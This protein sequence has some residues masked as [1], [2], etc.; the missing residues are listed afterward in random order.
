MVENNHPDS[1]F[2]ASSASMRAYRRSP[3]GRS[4]FII[5]QV[6]PEKTHDATR[7]RDTGRNLT[8]LRRVFAFITFNTVLSRLPPQVRQHVI[9]LLSIAYISYL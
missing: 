7:T 5:R 9:K 2:E 1:S 6:R 3:A 8:H 4:G